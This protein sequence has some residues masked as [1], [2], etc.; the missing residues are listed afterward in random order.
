MPQIVVCDL[1]TKIVRAKV[2]KVMAKVARVASSTVTLH[3]VVAAD[4]FLFI[5]TFE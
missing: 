1:V 4:D 5:V 3:I 2:A